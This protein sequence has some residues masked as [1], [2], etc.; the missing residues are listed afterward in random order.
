MVDWTII[1]VSLIGAIAAIIV[2]AIH[3]GGVRYRVDQLVQQ[4]VIRELSD[5]GELA[6]EFLERV[7]DELEG[8]NPTDDMGV[9]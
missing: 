5:S 7:D 3:V 6:K 9:Q 1:G 4:Q 8:D 2:A